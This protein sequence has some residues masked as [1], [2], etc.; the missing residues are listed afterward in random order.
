MSFINTCIHVLERF[1]M[2]E[3]CT[4]ELPDFFLVQDACYSGVNFKA[5]LK[6]PIK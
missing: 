2:Q 6:I 5:E 1:R 4:N 3:R